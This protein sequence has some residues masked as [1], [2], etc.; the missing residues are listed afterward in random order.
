M[1]REHRHYGLRP[2]C[3][4]NR[5][6]WSMIFLITIVLITL[7]MAIAFPH[8]YWLFAIEAFAALLLGFHPGCWIG[9]QRAKRRN[10]IRRP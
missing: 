1:A 6:P 4:P 5:T 2:G 10:D 3:D 7:G 9:A 8:R